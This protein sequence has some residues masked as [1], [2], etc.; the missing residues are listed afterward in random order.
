MSQPIQI[1]QVTMIQAT[2]NTTIIQV[3]AAMTI[4]ATVILQLM[5]IMITVQVQA[6]VTMTTIQLLL[7]II[8]M[9]HLR[10][11]MIFQKTDKLGAKD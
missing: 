10:P 5:M 9:I 2:A 7:L 11:A 3:T 6:Q 1:L 8:T 4:Q